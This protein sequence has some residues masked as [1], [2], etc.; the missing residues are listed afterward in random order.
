MKTEHYTATPSPMAL[1][2]AEKQKRWYE[3]LK[4]DPVRYAAFQAKY[5]R[6]SNER[7]HANKHDEDWRERKN[8]L[9]RKTSRKMWIKT[10]ADPL[11]ME[12]KRDRDRNASRE[13]SREYVIRT[14]NQTT[15]LRA[16]MIPDEMISL[17]TEW[18]KLCRKLGT[19]YR[20]V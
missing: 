4:A 7:Y 2:K 12:K 5:N 9:A 11:A 14:I 13:L 6:A 15:G 8:E 20:T 10:K 1:R 3:K 17:K 18:L 16:N 19:K